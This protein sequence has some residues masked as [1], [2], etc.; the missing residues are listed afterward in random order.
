MQTLLHKS[1]F[2]WLWVLKFRDETGLL[3][4]LW[5]FLRNYC[6]TTSLT[7]L[8]KVRQQC[9]MQLSHTINSVKSISQGQLQWLYKMSWY[10]PEIYLNEN[11]P[12]LVKMNVL[13]SAQCWSSSYVLYKSWLVC[14]PAATITS[15]RWLQ[16]EEKLI[17]H[18]SHAVWLSPALCLLPP[19]T[20]LPHHSIYMYIWQLQR[21]CHNSN[22]SVL[23]SLY[24]LFTSH[25]F[26]IPL[27]HL[28]YTFCFSFP[29]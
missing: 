20:K 28:S 9:I 23:C 6:A 19:P 5:C 13:S 17:H 27:W 18:V 1:T 4:L 10:F 16:V 21:N 7:A 3:H 2:I 15:Y 8:R 14:L 11:F 26:L 24:S 12:F 29:T 25:I 22:V